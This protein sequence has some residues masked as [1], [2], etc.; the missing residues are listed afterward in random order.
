M[1]E[2]H[3]NSSRR[4]DVLPGKACGEVQNIR[5]CSPDY[6][7]LQVLFILIAVE[8]ENICIQQ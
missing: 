7:V 6:P 8:L 4:R 1:Q 5:R 3:V 2:K